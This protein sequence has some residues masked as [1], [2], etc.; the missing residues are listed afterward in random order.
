[1]VR[2]KVVDPVVEKKEKKKK[3]CYW[4]AGKFTEEEASKVGS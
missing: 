2:C 1:M 4:S 3:S